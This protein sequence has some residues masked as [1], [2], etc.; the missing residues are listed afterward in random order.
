MGQ[1]LFKGFHVCVSFFS[2]CYDKTLLRERGVILAQSLRPGPLRWRSQC[3]EFEA[4]G[5]I[6]STRMKQTNELPACSLC[7]QSR[8]PACGM[9]LLTVSV[10]PH[11]S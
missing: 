2:I 4:T 9:G 7:I 3:Q 10:S 1:S 5:H 6:V 8:I 11:H